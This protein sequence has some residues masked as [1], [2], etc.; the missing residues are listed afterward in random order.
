MRNMSLMMR[1]TSLLHYLCTAACR[2]V[3]RHATVAWLKRKLFRRTGIQKNFGSRK[4][5]TTVPT[6]HKWYG[7]RDAVMKDRL[8]NRG[9]G[10]IRPGINLQ[11][12]PKKDERRRI[13]A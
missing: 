8:S 7:A 12:E 10:R 1:Y 9:H 11:E 6:V 2:K 5:I 13:N 3:S 4:D